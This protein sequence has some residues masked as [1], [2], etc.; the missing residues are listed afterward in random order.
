M[1]RD[2][3]YMDPFVDFCLVTRVPL[4]RSVPHIGGA[5]AKSADGGLRT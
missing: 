4:T 3:M 2:P 1:N 5:Q